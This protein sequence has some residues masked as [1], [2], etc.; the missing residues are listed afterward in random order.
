MCLNVI[1]VLDELEITASRTHIPTALT[2]VV[3]VENGCEEA[4]DNRRE[5]RVGAPQGPTVNCSLGCHRSPFDG[6]W[7]LPRATRCR[8]THDGSSAGCPTS[9]NAPH[10]LETGHQRPNRG[11]EA[12]QALEPQRRL[13][14]ISWT[15]AAAGWH[16]LPASTRPCGG[17][18][19]DLVH[20]AVQLPP[21]R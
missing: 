15:S 16:A 14:R 12:A 1:H 4:S 17:R 11:F 21:E 20:R 19:L 9:M 18:G 2:P 5:L 8:C 7:A 10:D 3:D 13:A 6:S